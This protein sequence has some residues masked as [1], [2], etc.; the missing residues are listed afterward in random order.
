[1]RP[2]NCASGTVDVPVV[3]ESPGESATGGSA[4][5]QAVDLAPSRWRTRRGTAIA[6]RVGVVVGPGA[7]SVVAARLATGLLPRPSGIGQL[8]GWWAVVVAVAAITLAGVDRAAR[9]LL[10]L[11]ALYRLALVFPDKAPSRYRIALRSGTTHQLSERVRSGESLGDTPSQAAENLLALIATIGRHDRITRGHSERV[12]AYSDLIGKQLGLSV[13]DREKLHWS[14]LVHDAGKIHVRSEVLNKAGRPTDEEWI[15]LRA[16][17][18]A[19][20]PLVEPLRPWLGEWV[21]AATQHH[22]RVDGAGYP[23]GL[24]GDEISLAGR[25]VAVADAYD[26]MTSARSYKRALPAEQARYELTR[27]SGTQFDADVVRA[28]LGISLGRLHLIAGP[29][30]WLSQIP[31]LAPV[32]TAAS[33]AG[34]TIVGSI[35]AA[36]GVFA[37]QVPATEKPA[38]ASPAVVAAADVGSRESDGSATG[39]T[40]SPTA[41]IALDRD[42][43]PIPT[44]PGQPGATTQ[45]GGPTTTLRGASTTTT[46]AGGSTTSTTRTNTTTSAG[47]ST[48]STTAGGNS[49]T[50]TVANPTTTSTTTTSASTSTTT[51]TTTTTT[52]VNA[53]PIARDDYP[54][55]VVLQSFTDIDVL[56]NDSDPGGA[57][58]PATLQIVSGPSRGSATVVNGMIRYTA[59]LLTLGTTTLTY[60][61]CDNGGA[62]AQAVVTITIIL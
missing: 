23:A 52:T 33:A 51:T 31:L 43:R 37:L 39:S 46:S 3:K 45:P 38:S 41:S 32:T 49:T 42:G 8:A 16:H 50:T 2:I 15:E 40:R 17:P 54:P 53:A 26:C 21:D 1:V 10:P 20:G 62:C 58:V 5:S 29:F 36:I 60:R 35:A 59:P 25:I 27:N 57:L 56:A 4:S 9:R 48:T 7:A 14:A 30:A 44:A 61:I 34:T 13:A 55:P 12:R 18:A 6:I 11:A 47:G 24:K 19:G 22:E 28:F